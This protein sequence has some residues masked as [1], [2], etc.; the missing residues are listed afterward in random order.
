MA[1][2]ALPVTV[3]TEIDAWTSIGIFAARV[4]GRVSVELNA[5]LVVNATNM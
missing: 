2:P 3:T 4:S 1:L 5:K